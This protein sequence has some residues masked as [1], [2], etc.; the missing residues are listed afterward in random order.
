MKCDPRNYLK[1]WISLR[2]EH[3]KKSREK[4]TLEKSKKAAERYLLFSIKKQ[5]KV[6]RFKFLLAM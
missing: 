4:K 1:Q 5:V 2:L 3:F 6:K